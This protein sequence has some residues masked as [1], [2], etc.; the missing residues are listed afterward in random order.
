M[1]IF[2]D[3]SAALAAYPVTDV[4]EQSKSEVRVTNT[5]HRPAGRTRRSAC[6]LVRGCDAGASAAISIASRT[7][8]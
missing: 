5:S 2:D 7:C 6:R 3:R 8:S 4:G 1:A